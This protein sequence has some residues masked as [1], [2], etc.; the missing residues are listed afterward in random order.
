MPQLN[1]DNQTTNAQGTCY[2]ETDRRA[3]VAEMI[4]GTLMKEGIGGYEGQTFVSEE[5]AGKCGPRERK[6]GRD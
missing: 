5:E 2:F 4:K 6:G 1:V 3:A